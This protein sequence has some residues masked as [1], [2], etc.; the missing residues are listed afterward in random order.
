MWLIHSISK[1]SQKQR[2]V[3]SRS[4]NFI[5]AL[6]SVGEG[7]VE[8]SGRCTSRLPSRTWSA[9]SANGGATEQASTRVFPLYGVPDFL[10]SSQ[11]PVATGKFIPTRKHHV[12]IPRQLLRIQELHIHGCRRETRPCTSKRAS[13]ATCRRCNGTWPSQ[14][15]LRLIVF[16]TCI[17][18]AQPATE[19][20]P[21]AGQA[22]LSSPPVN[23]QGVERDPTIKRSR[24]G[25][26]APDS[27]PPLSS[28]SDVSS[29]TFTYTS[30]PAVTHELVN[31]P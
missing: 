11:L 16:I 19:T 28:K 22:T 27:S 13:R 8:L 10:P 1:M 5:S 18:Q 21:W 3:H 12:L 4:I 7:G 26:G 15:D 25:Q 30:D 23:P 20:P 14:F 6:E 24:K 2:L 29:E 9:S 31:S 17:S